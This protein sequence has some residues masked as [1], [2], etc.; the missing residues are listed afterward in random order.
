MP[1]D[2][3]YFTFRDL[4]NENVT[5]Y[6]YNHYTH[7]YII[8]MYNYLKLQS[9]QYNPDSHHPVLL[10]EYHQDNIFYKFLPQIMNIVPG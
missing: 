9:I 8:E 10:H 1:M 3:Y 6:S 2:N 4:Y 5:V 7:S